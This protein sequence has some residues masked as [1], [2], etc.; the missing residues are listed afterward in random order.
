MKFYSKP[1]QVIFKYDNEVIAGIALQDKIICARCGEDF[2]VNS[3][4]ITNITNLTWIDISDEIASDILLKD[5]KK[6]LN[7]RWFFLPDSDDDRG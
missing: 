1:T 3:N 6:N 7:E 5:S 2:N 4:Y